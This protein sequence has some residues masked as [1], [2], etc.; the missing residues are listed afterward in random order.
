[1]REIEIA[2]V[3]WRAGVRV[4]PDDAPQPPREWGTVGHLVLDVVRRMLPREGHNGLRHRRRDHAG[5]DRA[6]QRGYPR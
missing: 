1:M 5:Q 6:G 4:L 2:E 3:P